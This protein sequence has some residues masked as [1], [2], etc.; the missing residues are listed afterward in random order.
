MWMRKPGYFAVEQGRG[1]GRGMG[2]MGTLGTSDT[3]GWVEKG[4]GL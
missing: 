2:N 4:P 1:R 3:E